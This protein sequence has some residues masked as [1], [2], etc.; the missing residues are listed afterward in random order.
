VL[1]QVSKLIAVINQQRRRGKQ[2]HASETKRIDYKASIKDLNQLLTDTIMTDSS[3]QMGPE[4][5]TK[6]S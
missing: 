5:F 3:R 2:L 6:Y 4:G 1:S